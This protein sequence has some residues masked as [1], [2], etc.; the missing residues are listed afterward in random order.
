MSIKNN[1]ISKLAKTFVRKELKGRVTFETL[2][3]YAKQSG[4][5][6]IFYRPDEP[7]D[8]IDKHDFREKLSTKPALAVR[9]KNE[10]YIFINS[11]CSTEHKMMFLAHELAHII[12]GHL[13]IDKNIFDKEVCEIEADAFT[14]EMLHYKS[15]TKLIWVLLTLCIALC[16]SVGIWIY[17]NSQN[18]IQYNNYISESE[19]AENVYI[20]P[21]GKKFHRP[22]CMYVQNKNCAS[23]PRSEAEKNYEPCSVCNP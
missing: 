16:A 5:M 13:D 4:Y 8:I 2:S 22:S 6:I 7:N 15:H 12:L 1:S 20:T 9:R 11:T 18:D 21:T 10:K 19:Q 23:L 3:H 17:A 14:Y